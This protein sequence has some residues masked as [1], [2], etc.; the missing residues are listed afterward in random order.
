MLKKLP[1][2]DFS[3]LKQLMGGAGIPVFYN[4]GLALLFLLVNLLCLVLCASLAGPETPGSLPASIGSVDQWHAAPIV[5]NSGIPD[6]NVRVA[7]FAIAHLGKT[8]GNGECWTLA[9]EALTAAGAQSPDD[10]VFGRE[11]VQNEK[12]LPGDIIQFTSCRFVEIRPFSQSTFDLGLPNHTAIIYSAQN[13][14]VVI[15]QQNSNN[16]KRV[17]TQT[18]NFANMVSGRLKVYRPLT[19]D[20]S[21]LYKKVQNQGMPA[22]FN[23]P[24]IGQYRDY[25]GR[26]S[27]PDV[28]AV[29]RNEG[30]SFASLADPVVS[31]PYYNERL[32]ISGR[33]GRLQSSGI[34]VAFYRKIPGY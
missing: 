12:W 23:S 20:S 19:R 7:N 6:L 16:D 24:E 21:F 11:L 15:I 33:I 5:A 30:R 14:V 22:S 13:G 2:G 25:G 32:E 4:R 10:F 34:H 9:Q 3:G 27:R 26:L 28:S 1:D 18:L 31:G 8:V 29:N 17:Q